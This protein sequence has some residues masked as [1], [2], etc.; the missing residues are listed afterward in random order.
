MT[1]PRVGRATPPQH[2]TVGDGAPG[3]PAAPADGSGPPEPT[4]ALAADE[5]TAGPHPAGAAVRAPEAPGDG[6]DR[7]DGGDGLDAM[8]PGAGRAAR[9]ARRGGALRRLSPV[10]GARAGRAA[11]QRWQ[12]YRE[13]QLSV[14]AESN[15]LQR[16]LREQERTVVASP[17]AD[18]A[19]TPDASA[20]AHTGRPWPAVSPFYVGFTFA[21]GALLAW[22]LFQN[23][24]RLTSV[25]TFLLVALFV[26]LAL[27]P[28]VQ[29]LT[30]RGVA[31]PAA[32]FVVFLGLVGVVAAIGALVVPPIASQTAMLV[33]R[34]PA[35]LQEL[36]NEPWIADLDEQ[37]AV[38]ERITA[39]IE[40]LTVDGATISTIFGGVL[41]A[42]GWVAGS[43]VGVLTS[44]ILTLYLLATLPRTKDAAYHLL[45]RSRR[46]RVSAIA[47]E[48]MRRVG[49]YALGQGA[50]ATINAVCSWVMMQIL[51]IPYPEMLAVLVGL[52]G[53]IPMVGA[54]LG[55][56]V[57]AL[58]AL[59]VSP[60]T[61]LVVI[62]Y[63]VIYQ[64]VENYV[65][66]P[67]IMRRT[68]SVPGAVTVV[69]V[70]IGGTLLGVIGALI[71]IPVAAGL[72]LIYH[73]VLVPR[74][75]RL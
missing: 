29:W 45:P 58:A 4:S 42:A 60:T 32:V 75:E 7:G 5:T 37:Y 72:L 39:E 34:A 1:G 11:V 62:V 59:S 27:E 65:I 20:G 12:D 57:V 44:A 73:E 9:P 21:F 25:F 70:L 19:G 33:D 13:R 28:V 55:A 16:E 52:L 15:R 23:L 26:T 64:Q 31:R 67:N 68:V 8:P 53:L 47:E 2:G 3:G 54:T 22:L 51:G 63:Y 41:G 66:V 24:T 43:L 46:D 14:L 35:F 30:R 6:G 69:A 36:A 74:Q 17:D 10:R 49:G 50:V 56:V 18:P 61:T 48:I 40:S 38:S 71:A